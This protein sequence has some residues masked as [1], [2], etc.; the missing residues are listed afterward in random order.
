MAR[1]GQRNVQKISPR[2]A[3][4]LFVLEQPH[5]RPLT[6]ARATAIRRVQPW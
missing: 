4:E 1:S 5:L 2:R 3:R 6:L